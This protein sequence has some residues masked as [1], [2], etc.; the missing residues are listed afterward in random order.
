MPPS[1]YVFPEAEVYTVLE[2]T[3][4][5]S[6]SEDDL[7]DGLS[8]IGDNSDPLNTSD[9]QFIDKNN[10]SSEQNT[11]DAAKTDT[12]TLDGNSKRD[13]TCMNLAKADVEK[14]NKPMWEKD[15]DGSD[16]AGFSSSSK[17]SGI[18]SSNRAVATSNELSD[19]LI[20]N[21]DNFTKIGGDAVKPPSFDEMDRE[22]AIQGFHVD[23]EDT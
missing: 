9:E 22:A 11:A 10:S 19:S 23:F 14:D 21:M 18:G 5:D 16:S 20:D 8:D 2:D 17:E 12:E 6:D 3:D 13:S 1:R 7:D 4:S 15:G